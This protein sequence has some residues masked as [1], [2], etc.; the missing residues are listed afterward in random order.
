MREFLGGVGSGKGSGGK[1]WMRN[2]SGLAFEHAESVSAIGLNK[3]IIER[4]FPTT[5]DLSENVE[6]FFNVCAVLKCSAQ[7]GA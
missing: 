7:S 4:V 2:T 6:K 5:K 3:I 1:L